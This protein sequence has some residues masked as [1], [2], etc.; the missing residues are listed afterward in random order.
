MEVPVDQIKRRPN[1]FVAEGRA[2]GF[3]AADAGDARRFHQPLDLLATDPGAFIDQ[4]S[5]DARGAI[6]LPGSLVDRLDALRQIR[7]GT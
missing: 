1:P 4:F 2:G 3:A 7:I 5:M 6:G